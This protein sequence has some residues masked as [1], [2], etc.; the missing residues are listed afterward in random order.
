MPEE[1]ICIFSEKGLAGVMEA[2]STDM[3]AIPSPH[4]IPSSC[5]QQR[6][7]RSKMTREQR[8]RNKKENIPVE[9]QNQPE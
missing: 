8:M 1:F 2:A 6:S 3:P 9:P 4:T 5:T 7:L